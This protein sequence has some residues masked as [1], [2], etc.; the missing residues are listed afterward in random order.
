MTGDADV[1]VEG[2]LDEGNRGVIVSFGCGGRRRG[3]M[4]IEEGG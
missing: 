2:P 4:G 1:G 3:K